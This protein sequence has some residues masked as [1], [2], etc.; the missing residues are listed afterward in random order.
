MRKSVALGLTAIFVGSVAIRLSPLLFFLY[1]G[2]DTGEYFAILRDLVRTGRVSHVYYGWGITYPYFPGMFF[3]QAGLIETAGLDVPTVLNLLVP[4]LG[5][6]AVVPMFLIAHRVT[7]DAR[8]AL[9]ASAFLMGA[10]PQAYTTAHAAPAT[11]GDLLA[12]TGLF[13]FLRLRTDR[14]A[15]VPLV[16]VTGALV[17]TH[18]LSLYFFLLMVLGTIVIRGL[19]SPWRW[20][21]G[22]RREVVYAAILLAG[23]FTYWLG[24]ATTFRDSI[25]SDVDIRPW[26]ALIVL[27]PIGIGLLAALIVARTRVRWR[28][29]P[30]YPGVRYRGAAYAAATGTILL[31][32]VVAVVVGVPGTSFRVPPEGL[33][34]FVPLVLLMSLAAPGRPFLDFEQD[35]L[36]VNAWLVALL[37]SAIVGITVAPRVLIPYRHME[38][39]V[40]PFAIFAGVGF[41]RT[42]DLTAIRKGRRMATLVVLGLLLGANALSALPPPSSLAGWREGTVPAAIDPAYWARDQVRGLVV[43]DHHG[44]TIVFGFGGLNATWDRTRTPF[45]SAALADP[46]AGLRGIDSPSGLKDGAYVWIDRDMEVG[47][48]LTPWETA[49]PMSPDVVARFDAAP[50]VKVFDNGY[51]RLYWIEWG[52]MP[53]RC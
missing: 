9:F 4:M 41:F 43:S 36:A 15:L 33:L 30:P 26:W 8:V 6:L 46:C 20:T 40:V 50:F 42:L 11:L 51:A 35:G 12:L 5:A 17:A 3:V 44:S 10:I 31:L 7:G 32:G 2:S 19:V 1:W 13:L 16:L 25:L 14:A 45:S 48:R 49:A 24:Y 53:P 29:R 18:H 39:L 47:V 27:F 22:T 23:T 37:G 34:Y 38:Y 28:H 52:S 21:V